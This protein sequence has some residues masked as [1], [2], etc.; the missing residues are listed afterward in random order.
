MTTY[1]SAATPRT[2]FLFSPA[3]LAIV[4]ALT[5]ILSFGLDYLGW[6][7]LSRHLSMEVDAFLHWPLFV[8]MTGGL[9]LVVFATF[10][11]IDSLLTRR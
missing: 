3:I 2:R 10:R 8:L 6:F 11:M 9:T 4:G 7:H 5:A 1:H